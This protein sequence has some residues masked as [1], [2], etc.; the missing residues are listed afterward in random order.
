MAVPPEPDPIALG[1]GGLES[2]DEAPHASL[3]VLRGISGGTLEMREP[4]RDGEKL[5]SRNLFLRGSGLGDDRSGQDRRIRGRSFPPGFEDPLEKA[6]ATG[7]PEEFPPGERSP[8][9]L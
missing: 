8:V 2:G 9:V 3:S 6:D 7:G 1:E 5:I 4:I